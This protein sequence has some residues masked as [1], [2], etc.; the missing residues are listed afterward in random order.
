MSS[1]QTNMFSFIDLLIIVS[2]LFHRP[3]IHA[4]RALKRQLLVLKG[5][6]EVFNSVLKPLIVQSLIPIGKNFNFEDSDDSSIVD[7]E[8]INLFCA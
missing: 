2:Y 8:A 6:K 3:S 7:R 1:L 4:C 5:D